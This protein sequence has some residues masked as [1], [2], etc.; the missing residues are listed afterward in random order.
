MASP[1]EPLNCGSASWFS[2]LT[3]SWLDPLV[4]VGVERQA[5]PCDAPGLAPGDDTVLNTHRLVRHLDLAERSR[6]R[7]PLLRAVVSTFWG[8]LLM[9]ESCRIFAHLIGLVNPFLLQ[10]VLIFQEKQNSNEVVAKGAV[11]RG[12]YGVAALL[13]LALFN[14]FFNSQ[15]N[16]FQSRLS[17]R[18]GSALKGMVLI[19]C[20]QGQ[21]PGTSSAQAAGEASEDDGK[22]PTV[23]NVISFDVGP[24]VEIIWIVLGVWLFP[25]QLITVLGALYM[26]VQ[27]AVFPGL[28]TILV[29]K[30]MCFVMLYVDGIYREYLL[31]RKDARLSNCD[32]SFSSIRTLQML[33]WVE[34]FERRIMDSRR[35]EL[36][37]ITVRLWMEKMVAALDYSLSAIVTLVTLGYFVVVQGNELKASVAL[38][39]IALIT[40]LVGPFGQIPVWTNHYL[41]WRS[42]YARVNK[43][44]GLNAYPKDGD[45]D[46]AFLQVLP[47]AGLPVTVQP[48]TVAA[49]E[50]CSLA[51]GEAAAEGAQGERAPLL[52]EG[53]NGAAPFELREVTMRMDAGGLTVVVGREGQGKTSL[54][55]A[56]LGEMSVNSG[57]VASPAVTRRDAQQAEGAAALLLPATSADVRAALEGDDPMTASKQLAVPY[58]AQEAMFFTGSVR[59]NILFGEAHDAEVYDR[60]VKACSL[61][62]DFE[63]MPLGDLSEVAQGG[64]TL[65]GGQK[66]RVGL[67]RAVYRAAL[68]LQRRPE[69]PPLVLLD[70]PICA[71]DRTVAREVVQALLAPEAGLL[72]RCAVVFATADP[73]WLDLAAGPGLRVAVLRAGQVVAYGRREELTGLDLPELSSTRGGSGG[74]GGAASSLSMPM[75]PPAPPSEH[76]KPSN[77]Q[78]DSNASESDREPSFP[79]PGKENGDKLVAAT[80][81]QPSKEQQDAARAIFKEHTEE[82]SVRWKTY[83]AYFSAVGPKMLVVLCFALTGIMVF[84]SMCVLWVTYWV[85]E[86]R[87][88]TFMYRWMLRLVSTPPEA[89]G[90]LLLVYACFVALFTFSNFAGHALEILGGVGASK[91]IFGESLTATMARPFRW[92]DTNP[93]GRILN[94][95][96]EDVE[97]MDNSVTNILGVI[98]G[99]VLFFIGHTLI[100]AL[101]NPI[102]LCL[103][104]FIA[105]GL[106]YYARYYRMTIREIQRHYLV[107]MSSVYQ[108]MVEAIVGKVTVRAYDGTRRVLCCSLDGLDDFQRLGFVKS[109]L[110]FW[111]SLRMELVGYSLGAFSTLYPVFQHFGILAPQS[112]AL[113]GFSITFSS[114]VVGII[115]QFVMNYSDLEMQLVSIERLREYSNEKAAR[116]PPA[117]LPPAIGGGLCLRDVVVTYRPGLRP[118][119]RGVSLR[120]EPGEV[121]AI[122]GRTGAGKSSLL[123][124]ALQL[125]PYEGCIEVGGLS[126]GQLCPKEVRQKV[127]GVV[128]QQPVVFSGT[129]RWNLDPMGERTDEELWAVLQAVGLQAMCR[130]HRD[131]LEA[132]MAAGDNT[133]RQASAL[134]LSQG[135]QQL[136]CAARVLLRKP[137]VAMLDE[138]TAALPREIAES[139]ASA[140]IN[141]FKEMEAVV[142]LVTHQ[143]ELLPCCE[144][145]V[146]IAAGRVASNTRW[147]N[148]A[149]VVA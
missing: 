128:P 64:S 99:A 78:D 130:Q 18:M 6:K 149:P 7:H 35:E 141:R 94:R 41:I 26:Q 46:D 34:P 61:E 63:T 93:T 12:M 135:Q 114:E 69:A 11:E 52:G 58:A 13:I 49:L 29:A 107:S 143:V 111:I 66:A 132:N 15:L 37:C 54:V 122:V 142:L 96:S 133:D 146:T 31:M 118:A 134:A 4:E 42:A 51:W 60:V 136:L 72:S 57:G 67:A 20:V 24:N 40:S 45:L 83:A 98:F 39:V 103:L 50:A 44:I 76:A 25:I 38:P 30:S 140:L 79:S 14:I 53:G 125:V 48:P 1:Q 112:A 124:A 71:L 119:L 74:A 101:A 117:S 55:K 87:E 65:S 10:Q 89:P 70:D 8:S 109:S 144:R 2:Y 77:P 91:Q 62:L 21:R 3:F 110:G 137:R 139:A 95:F 5:R 129:L 43:Y 32:E 100:L 113:V 47:S 84:Q 127:V 90:Q 104:P 85:S 102:S 145:V 36:H 138:V 147:S 148:G 59:S 27:S 92:W 88:K 16:F 81:T 33:S 121:A 86:E 17:L 80:Q 123:L 108:Y 73:W 97:V 106:E 82:G 22:T 116:R 23:Y 126:L 105:F 9:L 56:L 75:L 68:V 115:R 120:F 131:G 19:R 28:Y